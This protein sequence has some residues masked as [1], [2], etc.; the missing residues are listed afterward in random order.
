MRLSDEDVSKQ[1]VAGFQGEWGGHPGSPWDSA[2]DLH[3]RSPFLPKL[4]LAP[5]VCQVSLACWWLLPQGPPHLCSPHRLWG[6]GVGG[7]K[8]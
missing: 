8:K 2:L 5:P 4:Y 7:W 6:F 1:A 3:T